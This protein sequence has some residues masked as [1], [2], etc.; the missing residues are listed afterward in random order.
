MATS[1]VEQIAQKIMARLGA[2]DFEGIGIGSVA[3]TF[4]VG[5]G[6]YV[7]PTA[8]AVRPQRISTFQP[9]DFRVVVTQDNLIRNDAMSC[10]GNPP[11]QA[12]DVTFIIACIIRQSETDVTAVDSIKNN[13]WG[14][15][16]KALVAGDWPTWDGL[17]YNSYIREV[18]NYQADDGRDSGSKLKLDV[19]FRTSELD[20]FTVRGG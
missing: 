12:W 1:I 7:S 3:V 18:E 10:P 6:I 4:G 14:E 17:A 19:H 9:K 8:G 13:F 5:S 16:H 11:S 2:M 15:V 20:P